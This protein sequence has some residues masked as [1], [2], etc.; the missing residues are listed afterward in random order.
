MFCVDHLLSFLCCFV[1]VVVVAVYRPSVSCSQCCL[2][3]VYYVLSL[4]V[5]SI[6]NS[7]IIGGVMV[8]LLSSSVV[9]RRLYRVKPKTTI[10]HMLLPPLA[11]SMK[12]KERILV[13]SESE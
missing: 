1:V 13:G 12:E 4:P 3:I 8:S 9:D 7:N 6:I 5:S 2:W 11:R 10:W